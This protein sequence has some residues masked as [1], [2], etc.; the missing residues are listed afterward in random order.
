V[1]SSVLLGYHAV[2]SV[3]DGSIF[4]CIFAL[5]RLLSVYTVTAIH[6]SFV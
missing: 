5:Y 2:V 6:R 1:N 3:V 4:K